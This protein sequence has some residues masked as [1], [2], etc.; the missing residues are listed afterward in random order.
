MRADL[1]AAFGVVNLQKAKPCT[2]THLNPRIIHRTLVKKNQE[3]NI[4]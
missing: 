2:H 1:Y 3:Q 4:K